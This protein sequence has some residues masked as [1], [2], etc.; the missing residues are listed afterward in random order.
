MPCRRAQLR[1][2]G[3]AGRRPDD[4]ERLRLRDLRFQRRSQR[5]RR[6]DAAVADAAAAIDEQDREILGER[7]VL[8]PV[9]HDDDVR[10]GEPRGFCARHAVARDDGRR[11][12]RQ[13]Q[14]LVT[15]G[16]GRMDSR[17]DA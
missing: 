17:I 14:R 9:V 16:G 12:A 11:K 2:R 10:A 4:D 6:N 3:G 1:D 13:E 15:D 7:R 8:K 5:T